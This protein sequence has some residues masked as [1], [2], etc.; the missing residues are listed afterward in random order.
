MDPIA[1][2]RGRPAAR[3]RGRADARRRLDADRRPPPARRRRRPGAGAVPAWSIVSARVMALVVV[4]PLIALPA[5][6]IGGVDAFDDIARTL[7]PRALG[8]SLLLGVG[9]GGRHPRRRRRAGRARVVLRLPR[10]ALARLGA[11]AA[12]GDA[13]ATCWSSSPSASTASPARCTR[14][15]SAAGLRI[16]GLRTTAGRDRDPHRRALPVRLRAGPQRVPRPVPPGPRSGPVPGAAATGRRCGASR[17]RW[18]A[19][20]LAAGASLAVMEAL[21]DFGTVDL[22]GIQALTSV[23]YRV[24]YGDLRPGRPRCSSPPCWWASP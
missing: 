9:R 18:L 20:R 6:F 7:L 22:L 23:I 5:S 16:P 24:W 14:T 8:N 11:R 15:C 1:V 2:D 3:R 17:S 21:A 13:G 4:G 10:P 19:R 12:D